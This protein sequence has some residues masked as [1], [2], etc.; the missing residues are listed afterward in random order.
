MD[1]HFLEADMINHNLLSPG[2]KDDTNKRDRPLSSYFDTPSEKVNELLQIQAKNDFQKSPLTAKLDPKSNIYEDSPGGDINTPTAKP[3]RKPFRNIT[4]MMNNNIGSMKKKFYLSTRNLRASLKPSDPVKTEKP[5]QSLDHKIGQDNKDD[6]LDNES[7]VNDLIQS[8]IQ[9]RPIRKFHSMYEINKGRDNFVLKDNS[10]L[11]ESN[12]N[13]FN[14]END[15]IPRM[16]QH[17]LFKLL[18]NGYDHKFDEVLVVDCRFDYEF[19]GGHIENAINVSSKEDL[20]HKFINNA[21]NKKYLLVFHCEFSL[22]RGPTM[23]SHLRKC[24]RILNSDKYPKLNYPDIIILDGGYKKFFDNYKFKCNPQNYVEMNDLNYSKVCDVELDKLRKSNKLVKAKS[25]NNFNLSRPQGLNHNR[26][27]SHS[28]ITSHSE[29][30][31]ILKRQRSSS[32]KLFDM[33]LNKASSFSYFNNNNN[34]NN[35]TNNN[36]NVFNDTD[37]NDTNETDDTVVDNDT[38]EVTDDDNDNDNDKNL[39]L[40]QPPTAIFRSNKSNY[41]INS[42]NSSLSDLSTFSSN[43]SSDSNSISNSPI[44]ES[45]EFFENTSNSFQNDLLYKAQAPKPRKKKTMSITN[46][47]ASSSSNSN[48]SCNSGSNVNTNSNCNSSTSSRTIGNSSEAS[49]FTFPSTDL[50]SPTAVKSK[51]VSNLRH[52]RIRSIST[53]NNLSINTNAS[54]PVISSPLSNLTPLPT[55]MSTLDTSMSLNNS[56]SS[57]I[58]P[59]NDTPVDFP[60][61]SSRK[62]NRRGSN[63]LFS[64]NGGMNYNQFIDIDDINEVE[65]EDEKGA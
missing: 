10:L 64:S 36:T 46:L 59:I 22:F 41:S 21:Q 54:S 63:S 17:S 53:S 56:Q 15:I 61:S 29:N 28:T 42:S 3:Q 51:S 16:D 35:N 65:D 13:F 37:H 14:I 31:K 27:N 12:I 7:E 52:S 26:S 4:N 30:L 47:S 43:D 20:E 18:N 40:F 25:Y 49:D 32:N 23:A 1:H 33:K 11:G 8:P 60:I 39:D 58:D 45:N 50:T 19:I 48:L 9:K 55:P 38:D 2:R 24:D 6:F 57:M 44:F 34:N 5:N 62:H